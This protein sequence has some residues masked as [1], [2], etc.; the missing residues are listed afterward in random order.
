MLQYIK[1]IL[2]LHCLCE[3]ATATG[4]FWMNNSW[5]CFSHFLLPPSFSPQI[6]PFLFLP[7]SSSIPLC[8]FERGVRIL[9]SSSWKWLIQ[10]NLFY[11]A[12]NHKRY[13]S[14]GGLYNLHVRHPLWKI[15]TLMSRH[16]LTAFRV[17]CGLKVYQTVISP[18]QSSSC[19]TYRLYPIL[20][21]T[22]LTTEVCISGPAGPPG[23]PG[24]PV[25]G[26]GWTPFN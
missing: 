9:S 15:P 21:V 2:W 17:P 12:H 18:F 19:E 4:T 11:P 8:E 1:Y 23:A 7:L 22:V 14:L 3:A 10:F 16:F 13:I 25:S 26:Y 5:F 24:P 20:K 6:S